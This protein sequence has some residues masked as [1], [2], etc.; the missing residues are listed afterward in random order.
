MTL[1]VFL[2]IAVVVI[3]VIFLIRNNGKSDS[4]SNSQNEILAREYFEKGNLLFQQKNYYD[5]VE[6]YEKS[7]EIKDDE[8]VNKAYKKALSAIGPM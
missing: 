6:Y 2:G 4:K 3:L 7:L 5:A 1:K 8:E